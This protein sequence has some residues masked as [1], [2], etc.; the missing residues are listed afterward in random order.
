MQHSD[1]RLV[2]RLPVGTFR[3]FILFPL[4]SSDSEYREYMQ[5]IRARFP[6]G[7]LRVITQ[8]GS[9]LL[10]G[11]ISALHLLFPNAIAP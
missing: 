3:D 1:T 11:P 8:N 4:P 9:E 7:E 5:R 6:A 2:S 10:T